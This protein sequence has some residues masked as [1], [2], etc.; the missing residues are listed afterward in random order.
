MVAGPTRSRTGGL[1]INRARGGRAAVGHSAVGGLNKAPP[2]VAW[3]FD[4]P[5][6]SVEAKFT[7]N[8]KQR[9]LIGHYLEDEPNLT[10]LDRMGEVHGLV[11]VAETADEKFALVGATPRIAAG[12][13]SGRFYAATQGEDCFFVTVESDARRL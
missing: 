12:I 3:G 4:T 5:V 13:R 7:S 9:I 2:D 6:W 10:L 1:N 8:P 11:V